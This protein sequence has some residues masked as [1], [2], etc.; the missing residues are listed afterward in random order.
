MVQK[1]PNRYEPLELL[2]LGQERYEVTRLKG[3]KGRLYR[4]PSDAIRDSILIGPTEIVS[5]KKENTS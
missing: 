5:D 1:N 4:V 2:F 3:E